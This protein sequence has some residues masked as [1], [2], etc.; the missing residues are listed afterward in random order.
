MPR[1][2]AIV[3]RY[4]GKAGDPPLDRID[5]RMVVGCP[6]GASPAV[7][8]G[9]ASAWP[10]TDMIACSRG[11]HAARTALPQLPMNRTHRLNPTAGEKL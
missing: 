8:R 11:F 1:T 6:G 9:E 2:P 4:P 3:Q 10:R 7:E 5:V